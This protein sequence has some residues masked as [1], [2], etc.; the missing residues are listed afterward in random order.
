M[1]GAIPGGEFIEVKGA[2]HGVHH[3]QPEWLATTI[4]DWLAL[5]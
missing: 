3:E 1:A 2:S 5:H 4:V